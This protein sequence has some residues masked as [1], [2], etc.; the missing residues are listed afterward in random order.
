VAAEHAAD[1][2]VRIEVA[3][4]ESATVVVEEQRM[5]AARFRRGVVAR[6]EWNARVNLQLTDNADGHRFAAENGGETPAHLTR[7]GW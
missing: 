2:V 3:I 4:G 6:R 5:G 7:L 1:A